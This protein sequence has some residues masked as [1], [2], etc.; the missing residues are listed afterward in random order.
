MVRKDRLLPP[1]PG[2]GELPRGTPRPSRRPPRG[3]PSLGDEEE[4][5]AGGEGPHSSSGWQ[6]RPILYPLNLGQQLPASPSRGS[7]LSLS[8]SHTT[9]SQAVCDT[10]RRGRKQK[11]YV[12]ASSF[13]TCRPLR[14]ASPTRDVA[15][16]LPGKG[17]VLP[18]ETLAVQEGLG[19]AVHGR[20]RLFLSVA[21]LR[22]IQRHEERCFLD[23]VQRLLVF[24]ASEIGLAT[25]GPGHSAARSNAAQL[26]PVATQGQLPR[27]V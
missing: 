3:R 9:Q 11:F 25:L 15:S 10:F 19:V 26:R 14:L 13:L 12:Q 6:A 22:F 5:A 27:E 1:V 18:I 8:F 20:F 7:T 17:R 23:G 21:L 24:P 4:E 2:K 16:K